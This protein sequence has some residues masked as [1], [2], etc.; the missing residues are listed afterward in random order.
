MF[1]CYD[2]TIVIY[3]DFIFA[4]MKHTCVA[5]VSFCLELNNAL[6][7]YPNWRVGL[8]V[9]NWAPQLAQKHNTVSFYKLYMC[10]LC[11]FC[12]YTKYTLILTINIGHSLTVTTDV[13]ID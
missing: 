12:A 11:F 5:I 10:V 3:S 4:H 7:E 9:R 2:F 1:Y 8:M 6:D 13:D